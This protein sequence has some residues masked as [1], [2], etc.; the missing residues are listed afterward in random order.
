MCGIDCNC[1]NAF[2][3]SKGSKGDP[4]VNGIDGVDGVDGQGIDHVSFTSTTAGSGLPNENGETDTYTQWGDAGET[5]VV[6]TF[7]VYNGADGTTGEN[8]TASNEGAGVELF[9]QKTGDNLEFKTVLGSNLNVTQHYG[10]E[11][12]VSGADEVRLSNTYDATGSLPSLSATIPPI[13]GTSFGQLASSTL[14]GDWDHA[15][16][17]APLRMLK[18]QNHIMFSGAIKPTTVG[19]SFN[20]PGAT[21]VPVVVSM[22]GAYR[23]IY[24]GAFV[25]AVTKCVLYTEP[26][27]PAEVGLTL[28]MIPVEIDGNTGIINLIIPPDTSIT[29]DSIFSFDGCDFFSHV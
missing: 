27:L 11:L 23:P 25:K 26:N 17:Y 16:G 20:S 22:G 14:L 9:K 19:I 3:L 2:C 18:D 8:N 15:P 7:T 13:G 4:G 21:K 6:G 24:D 29:S 28:K 5:I 1:G 12:V 10:M